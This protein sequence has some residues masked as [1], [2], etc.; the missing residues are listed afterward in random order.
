MSVCVMRGHSQTLWAS[1]SPHSQALPPTT[2]DV[3][4]PHSFWA[5]LVKT[6]GP[7]GNH[8]GWDKGSM[9]TLKLCVCVLF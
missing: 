1:D 3:D 5:L 7:P 6:S 4:K 9:N 2:V 8:G